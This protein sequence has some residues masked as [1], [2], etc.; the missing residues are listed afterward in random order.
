MSILEQIKSEL[1]WLDDK[2][3]FDLTRGK[4]SADQLN[5]TQKN[6]KHIEIP[7]EMDG[8]DLRNYGN[9][10]GIPSARKLG[11]QILSTEF[12][13]T[14]ALDNSSLT[15]MQQLVSCA[16]H[17][18]FPKSKLSKKT[19][20]LCPVPGYDRHFKL[21]ENFGVEMIPMPFQDDGPDVNVISDLISKDDDISGIVCVPRHSNP[22]G[23]VYSDQNVKEIFELIANKKRNFMVLWDNAYACHDFRDT[24][25]QTP[26]M[27]LADEYELKDNLFIV[28]STSK[29]TL[30]GSGLAFFASSELNISKFIEYRN[31]L[32][33][34]PNKLNQGMHVNYFKKSSL[35]SQM[36]SLKEV[37]LPKFELVEKY[38]DELK[39]DG[40]C[41]YIQPSGGYFISYES[42]NSNAEQIIEYCSKLGLKLLPI[43]SCF[44][45]QKD[46]KNS[47]IRIAPTFPNLE[48]L[49][50]CMEIFSKVVKKLN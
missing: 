2:V 47:N 29:I 23:H 49:E 40:F 22:T 50:R 36:E 25:N 1:P 38:L 46:P 9:P 21:L 32:T 10:E 18:G 26:V 13:E 28:G 48:N 17:L 42:S 31:S 27:K 15:I 7:F 19:K 41:D 24:K 39:K 35:Q 14:I 6:F 20:F 37:I 8:I 5:V 12:D 43:G 44:P 16:Y 34:G 4:P 3:S 33:P 11:A 30:A 45:Y